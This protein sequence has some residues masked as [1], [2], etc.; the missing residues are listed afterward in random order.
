MG[1]LLRP[2]VQDE[3]QNFSPNIVTSVTS[4]TAQQVAAAHMHMVKSQP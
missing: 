1:C 2:A 4:V 3:K